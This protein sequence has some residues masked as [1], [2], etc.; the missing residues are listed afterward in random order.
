[1]KKS[2]RLWISISNMFYKVI[3]LILAIVAV[4]AAQ[5]FAVPVFEEKIAGVRIVSP[6]HL[7]G[8]ITIGFIIIFATALIFELYKTILESKELE[9]ILILKKTE[10]YLYVLLR[11]INWYYMYILV[12]VVISGVFSYKKVLAMILYTILYLVVTYATYFIS[13]KKIYFGKEISFRKKSTRDKSICG[14]VV[15]KNAYAEL[16]L[17]G[18]KERYAF[19]ELCIGKIVVVCIAIILGKEEIVVSMIVVMYCLLVLILILTNDVYWKNEKE[20]MRLLRGTGISHKKYIGINL[21]SGSIF[22]VMLLAVLISVF[23]KS[24]IVGIVFAV[25]GIFMQLYWNTI[26]L[27]VNLKLPDDSEVL[28]MML[29]IIWIIAGIIPVLNLVLLIW[30]LK[31]IAL[32]WQGEMEC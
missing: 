20:K 15:K 28:A 12:I 24:I 1:M 2:L 10:Y 25:G 5:I 22:N 16:I 3:Q 27:Y 14:E 11:K 26:Y 4:T 31:K 32:C 17:L 6:N 7:R 19:L 29:Y 8:F 13:C 30:V 23:S 18:I 21:I 9:Y